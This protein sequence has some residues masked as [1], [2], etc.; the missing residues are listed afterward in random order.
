MEAFLS[1]GR[2]S[3][4]AQEEQAAPAAAPVVDA[5]HVLLALVSERTG[6][7]VDMLDPSLDLE[8]DL[9]I[10][11]I[12]RVEVIGAL[13]ERIGAA[14]QLDRL[15]EARTLA[16]MLQMLGAPGA[17][18]P[19][20]PQ[21]G[22]MAVRAVEPPSGMLADLPLIG[23]VVSYEQGH[24]LVATRTLDVETD[25]FLRDHTFGG[26]VSD[27]DPALRGL[28]VVPLTMSI[29][30][31]AQAAAALDGG[32]LVTGVRDVR[33]YQWIA[34][35]RGRTTLR[36]V[37]TQSATD[38]AETDV[39]IVA[40]GEDGKTDITLVEGTVMLADRF[41][42]AP[43]PIDPLQ[44]SSRASLWTE[45]R[46]YSEIMFHG[47]CFRAVG[48]MDRWAED[49]AEATLVALPP[50]GLF[51]EIDAPRFFT[52]PVILD[53]AGQ[54][55]GFWIAE[56]APR[57]FHVFPFRVDRIDVFGPPFRPGERPR[58]S[59]RIQ[60]VGDSQLRSTVDVIAADGTVRYRLSGWEDKRFE[61][62]DAFY[63]FR[64][65]PRTRRLGRAWQLPGSLDAAAAGVLVDG[66]PRDLLEA[67]GR[68]WLRVL[69][70]LVLSRRERETWNSLPYPPARR[71]DWL[72]G[73]VAA[74]EAV[75]ELLLQQHGL[76]VCSADVEIEPDDD[77][78][79]RVTGHWAGAV[80]PPLVSISHASGIAAAMA[81]EP[82][83]WHGVGLDI[84]PIARAAG[85]FAAA[86]FSADEHAL[87]DTA[88]DRAEWQL[89]LWCAKEAAGKAVGLGLIQGPRFAVAE[90]LDQASGDVRI[91]LLGELAARAGQDA[92]LSARTFRDGALV[93]AVVLMQRS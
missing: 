52:D 3:T 15:T 54:V 71:A 22:A 33:A 31:L 56:G 81:L 84:E 79:P 27:D 76:G 9:G 45:E 40:P 6:Y 38:A 37:A 61:L 87:V 83:T 73:R 77:R 63:R 93:G 14:A 62:P 53:A 46:L 28:P 25:L 35:D 30:M 47:P 60:M 55:V 11:S 13:R 16:A 80:A 42:A 4:R 34:L 10:D 78:C 90:A 17:S 39:R 66:L 57:A 82:D 64:I 69:S 20:A 41:P 75:R 67:H 89:R 91:A 23:T 88:A 48:S 92:T 26:S 12:K 72:L 21:A 18:G 19:G 32:R 43:A 8:A 85:H 29:E 49:G 44:G 58:C 36:I 1:G 65:D 70:H 74:K 24:E 7:P 86:A 5:A 59:A 50:Q 2:P 68:I 51:R